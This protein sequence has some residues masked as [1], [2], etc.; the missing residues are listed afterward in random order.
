[1]HVT[2]PGNVES[3]AVSKVQSMNAP[4]ARRNSRVGRMLGEIAGVAVG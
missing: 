1:M 2:I 3:T 4:F